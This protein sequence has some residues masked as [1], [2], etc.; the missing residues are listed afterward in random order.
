MEVICVGA[1]FPEPQVTWLINGSMISPSIREKKINAKVDS[2]LA[3]MENG[4]NVHRT[5]SKIVIT[6]I[7]FPL[8]IQCVVE[9]YVGK[10]YSNNIYTLYLKGKYPYIFC[11]SAQAPVFHTTLP[12]KRCPLQKVWLTYL[13]I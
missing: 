13:C 12:E 6:G 7:K 2:I 1:G 5:I 8:S 3:D 11:L 4:T 9:N 10:L